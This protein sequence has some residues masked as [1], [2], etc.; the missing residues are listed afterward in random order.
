MR[1]FAR[2]PHPFTAADRAAGFR[3]E[4]SILQAE[5]ARTQVL[6]RPVAGRHLFEALIRE[7][8]DLGRPDRVSLIFQRRITQRTPGT[9]RTRIITQGVIPTLHVSYTLAI[10]DLR[11]FYNLKFQ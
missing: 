2:L 11:L 9:F 4:L 5:F 6:D 10:Q 1:W 3:Y 8:L 7:N